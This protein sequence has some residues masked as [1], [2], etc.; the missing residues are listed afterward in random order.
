MVSRHPALSQNRPGQEQSTTT[1][2]LS[3]PKENGEKSA[4]SIIS[5]LVKPRDSDDEIR[6][7]Q[8]QQLAAACLCQEIQHL[9]VQSGLISIDSLNE[10][11]K[12]IATAGLSLAESNED[13]IQLLEHVLKVSNQIEHHVAELQKMGAR[14]GEAERAAVATYGRLSAEIDLL[15]LKRDIVNRKTQ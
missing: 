15:T 5:S 2:V 10:S 9:K 12:R 8:R 4:D 1:T 7:L 14:G 13:K 11:H 6:K 3:H